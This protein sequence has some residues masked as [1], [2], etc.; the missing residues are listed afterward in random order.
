VLGIYKGHD[1]D[2]FDCIVSGFV[3]LE[4]AGGMLSVPCDPARVELMGG[5]GSGGRRG[6]G[7]SRGLLAESRLAVLAR[8]WIMS[9]RAMR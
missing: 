7:S 4:G 8:T 3:V 1:D 6:T 2:V 5:L 9:S